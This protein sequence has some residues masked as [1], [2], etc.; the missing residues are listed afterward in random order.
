MAGRRGLSGRAKRRRALRVLKV[1]IGNASY[2]LAAPRS[3]YWRPGCDYLGE[4][5][6]LLKKIRVKDRDVVLI[7]EKALSTAK[8][9]IVD[10]GKVAPGL[11]AKLLARYWMRV[12]WGY[13]L[14]PLCGL[15]PSTVRFLRKYP[16]DYGARHK[17]VALNEAG[18]LAALCFGSEGGI[19]GS[20]LPYAY[21]SLPL[22]D[23]Y[24]EA[25]RIRSHIESVLKVHVTVVIV[26][27]DRCYKWGPAYVAPRLT[28]VEGIRCGG[29]FVTYVVSNALKLRGWPTPVACSGSPIPLGELLRLCRAAEIVRGHGAGRNVWEMARRF[30]TSLTGVTWEMLE[31]IPHYPV[32]VARRVKTVRGG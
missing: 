15:R 17:Q 22:R 3:R 30:G 27:S 5:T 26:D 12:V 29:G 19:D 32:V 18:L 2:A 13:L 7:S 25:E 23:A 21:V 10:E 6:R 1:R 16:L 8:G 31:R 28:Y 20:N 11:L 24:K 14:G 9:N 4:I